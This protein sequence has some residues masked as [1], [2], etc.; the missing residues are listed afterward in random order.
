MAPRA[1]DAA[2][3][4]ETVYGTS[5]WAAFVRS[6]VLLLVATMLPLAGCVS[7][8]TTNGP[9]KTV[10]GN[11]GKAPDPNAV[12]AP[13]QEVVPVAAQVLVSQ[14]GH[15][16]AEFMV[17]TNPL[18]ANHLIIAAHDYDSLG[19]GTMSCVMFVSKDGGSTWTE[20]QRIPGLDK[21]HLQFD[22]WVSFDQEGVAHFVCLDYFDGASTIPFYTYSEDGGLT[23]A[24]A[25]LVEPMSTGCDKSSLHAAR[26]GRVYIAC[27]NRIAY[28]DDRGKTWGIS[29]GVG[30]NPNG[31]VE[32]YDGNVYLWTRGQ[33]GGGVA[34]TVDRGVTWNRTVVGPFV[35]P[36]GFNDQN[37][38]VEQRP[39]TTL[40]SIWISPLNDHIFVAQQSWNESK[41]TPGYEVS[42]Y[43]SIDHGA[44]YEVRTTPA[45]TSDT[46]SPCHVTKPSIT[47]DEQGRV[48]LLVQLTNE[49]GH[50]KEVMFSASSDEG[51]TWV[52]PIILSKTDDPNSWANPNAFTPNNEGA[53]DLAM[54]LAENPQD[55]G[56]VAIGL[57]LTS[58]V[59][60]LQMRWNGEYWGIAS[61][62]KG[63]V[64][65]WIDHSN[66][67]VPQVFARLVTA[68]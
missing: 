21:P 4:A 22:G 49:G 43:R 13:I 56:Q 28:T 59:Q 25:I 12:I 34:Y 61:S 31:F 40:P 30:S 15:R 44:T 47:V 58:A 16:L 55:A 8:T 1:G 37:R 38:W 50:I 52:A 11:A 60:E 42:V 29:P 20:N 46:C 3:N 53:E 18:D 9:A 24:D 14:E 19:T 54:Y 62:P 32:D 10:A 39:W 41:E 27:G 48:G 57:G 66:D 2:G 26:D 51:M 36:P 5:F 45:F 33:G 6:V 68:Q 35:T 7:D 67:G 23:W 17:A 64:T 65:P 63:F